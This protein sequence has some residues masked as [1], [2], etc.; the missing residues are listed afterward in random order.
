MVFSVGDRR[1]LQVGEYRSMIDIPGWLLGFMIKDQ[2]G[3][4]DLRA[5]ILI[6]LGQA[7]EGLKVG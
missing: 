6:V 5:L 3:S 4:G 1:H 2:H 7:L